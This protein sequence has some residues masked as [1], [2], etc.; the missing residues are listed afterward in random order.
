MTDFR[1]LFSSRFS[2]C[3][4]IFNLFL[5]IAFTAYCAGQEVITIP[6]SS[7]GIKIKATVVLPASYAQSKKKYS[8][9]YLLHGFGGDHRTWPRI[10]P[11]K[12]YADTLQ[13]LFVCPDGD[14]SWYIDSRFK[15]K[16]L[17]ET[18]IIREVIPFIDTRYRTWHYGE[19]RAIMGVSMGGHGAVSLFAKHQDSFIGVCSI[20]GVMDLTEF[21]FEW[22][23]SDILGPLSD[24]RLLWS[25]QSCTGMTGRL[26]NC[27]KLIILDCGAEDFALRGN[28]KADSLLKI[29]GIQHYFYSRP[30]F[31]DWRY[32]STAVPAHIISLSKKL[33]PPK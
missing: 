3:S 33:P 12:L 32:V 9:I 1:F 4:L 10:A 13:L 20:S 23:L 28:I 14:N 31:H 21:P 5:S 30:G 19:G 7:M 11:L 8:V 29:A 18:H 17:F 27:S 2:H 26:K 24:N 15:N 16:S 22:N 25:D 6:S